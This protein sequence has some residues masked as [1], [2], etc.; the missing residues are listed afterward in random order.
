M[1]LLDWS[2]TAFVSKVTFLNIRMPPPKE[3][4]DGQLQPTAIEWH[5]SVTRVQWDRLIGPDCRNFWSKIRLMNS[6]ALSS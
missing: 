3:R 6:V 5:C 4:L 2:R 1:G